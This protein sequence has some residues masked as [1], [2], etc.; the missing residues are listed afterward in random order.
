MIAI[1]ASYSEA[2]M[3]IDHTTRNTSLLSIYVSRECLMKPSTANRRPKRLHVVTYQIAQISR[4]FPNC[5]NL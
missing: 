4:V 2:V 3:L 1:Y 5:S